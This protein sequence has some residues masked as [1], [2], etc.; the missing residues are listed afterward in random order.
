MTAGRIPEA[1]IEDVR[2]RTSLVGLVGRYTQLKARR[3]GDFWGRCPFHSENT[4]SFHVLEQR[5]RFKCFGCQESGNAFDFLELKEGLS[6]LDAVR[7]LA[8]VAGV[9]IPG[10]PRKASRP[11]AAI[12]AQPYRPEDDRRH[13]EAERKKAYDLWW[14]RRQPLKGSVA[15][16]Y[17]C[18]ARGIRREVFI[19]CPS[20]GC[21]PDAQFWIETASGKW[22]PVWTGPALVAALQAPSGRFAAVHITYLQPDGSDKLRL[23]ECPGKLRPSKKV[24]GSP[25]GAAIW[26]TPP[27]ERMVCGEGIETALSVIDALGGAAGGVAAYSL[28]N[29]AGPANGKGERDPRDG[30]KRLPHTVPDMQRPG[31]CFKKPTR[32]VTFLGDGDTKDQVALDRLLQRAV[33]RQQLMGLDA[34]YVV[35]A[36]GMDFNDYLRADDH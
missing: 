26:L 28:D 33:M 31:L 3:P 7:E 15:E 13:R 27:Q 22:E 29:M 23:Y 24:K 35:S 17:L 19:G 11:R 36:E 1:V 4:A 5:G 14:R 21:I 18:E 32:S 34:D 9:D 2:R 25:S 6:F 8:A 30:R 16:T 10:E 20:L 12:V